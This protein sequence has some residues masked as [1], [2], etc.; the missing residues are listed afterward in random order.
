M[1]ISQCQDSELC[2]AENEKMSMRLWHFH[3]IL[4]NDDINLDAIAFKKSYDV[5]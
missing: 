5:N 1:G 3:I 2:K 4:R